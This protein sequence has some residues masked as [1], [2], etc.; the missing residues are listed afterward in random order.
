MCSSELVN[1]IGEGKQCLRLAVSMVS[2]IRGS[3]REEKF[4]SNI[5]D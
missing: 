2:K 1:D 5:E 3:R 4:G